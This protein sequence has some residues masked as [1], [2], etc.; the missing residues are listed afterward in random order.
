MEGSKGRY[1]RQAQAVLV[2]YEQALRKGAVDFAVR[3]V[4]ANPD[5]AEPLARV[6]AKV[7]RQG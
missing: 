1:D 5:L 6:K 7:H 4:A 2:E 3:I